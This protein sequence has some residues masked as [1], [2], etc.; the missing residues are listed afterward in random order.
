MPIVTDVGTDGL[1][2]TPSNFQTGKPMAL[3]HQSQIAM[4]IPAIADDAMPWATNAPWIDSRCQGSYEDT[5]DA[6]R[7]SSIPK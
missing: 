7:D 1:C 3:P 4:S 5:I 2:E 6:A